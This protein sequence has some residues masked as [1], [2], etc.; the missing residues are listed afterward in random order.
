M[1]A[2]FDFGQNARFL[3]RFFEPTKRLVNSLVEPDDIIRMWGVGLRVV[4]PE[5]QD[6]GAQRAVLGNQLVDVE[7]TSRPQKGVRLRSSLWSSN[8]YGGS[9]R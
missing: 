4:H 7:P 5:A 6:A 9:S 8:Q 3:T 1:L 2:F